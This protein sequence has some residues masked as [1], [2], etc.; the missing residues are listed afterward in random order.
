MIWLQNNGFSDDLD[1]LWNILPADA[2]QLMV[3]IWL[4]SSADRA[5]ITHP[6]PTTTYAMNVVQQDPY[7]SPAQNHIARKLIP[8]AVNRTGDFLFDDF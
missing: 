4:T 6:T 3:N 1:N 7:L 8:I 5:N 2:I